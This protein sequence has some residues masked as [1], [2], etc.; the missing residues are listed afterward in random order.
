MSQDSIQQNVILLFD[1]ANLNSGILLTPID[2]DDDAA[3]LT[4]VDAREYRR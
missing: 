3:S 2:G 1:S 4:V